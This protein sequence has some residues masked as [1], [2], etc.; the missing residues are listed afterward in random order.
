LWQ[1]YG[2]ISVRILYDHQLFSLQDVGGGSRYYYELLRHVAGAPGVQAELLLGMNSSV[3]PLQ[4]LASE[5]MT[6]MSFG[7][8]LR[9]GMWRYIVNE[10]FSNAVAPFRGRMDVYHS[11][12]Y[13]SVPLVRAK[14]I[15][16]THCDCVQER[17]PQLFPDIGKIRRAK[18]RLFRQADAI[19]CISESSRKDLLSFYDVN[20]DKTRV[21]YLGIT[22]MAPCTAAAGML[23][24]HLRRKYILFVGS[25]APYKNFNGLL[26]AFHN[27]GLYESLDLLALG[28]GPLTKEETALIGKLGLTDSVISLPIVSDGVLAEAYAGAQLF[29]Y[30]S[31]CEG[32]GFPPLEAMSAG[33]PVLASHTSSIPEVC[34]DAPFYFDLEDATSFTRALLC[35]INDEPARRQAMEKGNKVAAR[36]S[37]KQCG[38]ATLALY[39]ECQ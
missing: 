5:R 16:A 11:T 21:I 9:P 8:S 12:L 14:R 34:L 10:A 18:K 6:V 19:I 24:T 3:F 17:F 30:P 29:V 39:R 25:R 33:C 15:V 1:R 28:G 7:G 35:A 32:F 36:Y 20:A 38:E 27:A 26:K 13:R 23:R 4:E 22:S 2:S 37:W 31:F